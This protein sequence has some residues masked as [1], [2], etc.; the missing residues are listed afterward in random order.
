MHFVETK[1]VLPRTMSAKYTTRSIEIIFNQFYNYIF[2]PAVLKEMSFYQFVARF[3]FCKK[4]YKDYRFLEGHQNPLL[5]V[6]ERP[7]ICIPIIQAKFV[8]RLASIGEEACLS[9]LRLIFCPLDT[10]CRQ[11]KDASGSDKYY[12]DNILAIIESWNHSKRELPKD[13]TLSGLADESS[14][15]ESADNSTDEYTIPATIIR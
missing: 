5:G 11:L 8:Q 15:S 12:F 6:E 2:R 14:G 9:A 13:D 3:Q 4:P 10:N 1:E 7:G